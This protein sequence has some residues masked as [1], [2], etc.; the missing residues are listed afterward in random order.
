MFRWLGAFLLLGLSPL[1]PLNASERQVGDVYELRLSYKTSGMN[2]EGQQTSSSSGHQT[3]IE[4]VIASTPEGIEL[5]IDLP[6]DE[7]R[8]REWKFPA[9]IFKPINGPL[10]LLNEP[11]L[12]ERLEAWLKKADWTREVCGQWIFTWNA[13]LIDCDPYSAIRSFEAHSLESS[14]YFE[15]AEFMVE[16]ASG[17]AILETATSEAGEAVLTARLPIDPDFI[18]RQQAESDVVVGQIT[19]EKVTLADATNMRCQADLAGTITETYFPAAEGSHPKRVRVSHLTTTDA[20]GNQTIQ[21]R[22]ETLQRKLIR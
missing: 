3:M 21:K 15:G 22:T 8:A 12:E 9:R 13:F 20:D 2:S 6:T 4:R 10:R 18:C 16:G 1:L 17:S 5:E 19:G 11:E 14:K 7:A